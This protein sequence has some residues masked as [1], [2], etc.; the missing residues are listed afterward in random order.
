MQ[1]LRRERRGKKRKR[2][3]TLTNL[4]PTPYQ[5]TRVS[6]HTIT[7][8]LRHHHLQIPI[9]YLLHQPIPAPPASRP[10]SPP[11]TVSPQQTR[12]PTVH[13]HIPLHLPPLPHPQPARITLPRDQ[14]WTR[15]ARSR[16]L[17]QVGLAA[18]RRRTHL[19]RRTHMLLCERRWRPVRPL[20]HHMNHKLVTDKFGGC[21]EI[22][23]S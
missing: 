15:M 3:N 7:P 11:P 18:Y 12:A 23:D 6:R 14:V 20:H 10:L 17:P 8:T 13:Q 5:R 21:N 19:L 4:S 16:I 2:V 22:L 9:D 1:M